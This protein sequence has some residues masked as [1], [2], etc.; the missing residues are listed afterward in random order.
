MAG[1]RRKKRQNRIGNIWISVIV[2]ALLLVMS[3]QIVKLYEK[4]QTYIAREESLESQ[5]EEEQARADQIRE[6]EEYTKSE[7]FIEDMAKSRL[8]LVYDNEVIFKKK[9]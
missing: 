5:L 4:N 3:T 8:G 2:A 1:K 7:K 9:K 6:Y